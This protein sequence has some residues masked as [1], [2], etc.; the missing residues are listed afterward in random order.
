MSSLAEFAAKFRGIVNSGSRFLCLTHV[1]P[2]GDAYGCILAMAH[3]LRE[4]GK[5]VSL[6]SETRVAD[7]YKFLPG[8][9]W[10]TTGTPPAGPFNAR[11]IL[12]NAN[13]ERAGNIPL[14]KEI[15]SPI[16]NVDHH[17]SNI[18]YGDLAYI[19]PK[20]AS[21]GEIVFDL[22]KAAGM[23]IP[24][25]TAECLFVAISTDTGSFQYPSV[26]AST[27]HIAGELMEC[28][29]DLGQISRETYESNPPRRLL[30]MR[31]VLKSV[32]FDSQDRIGYFWIDSGSYERSGARPEDSEGMIDHIRSI[33]SVLVAV[34]FEEVADENL[35]RIS[36]R[37]KDKRIDVNKIAQLFGG[38]G[39]SAAAGAKTKG[40][41]ADI[42]EKVLAAIR[43][44]M[45]PL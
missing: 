6:W 23:P 25:T 39:H 37:S 3:S 31:E 13:L 40:A 1:R 11:I 9:E 36:L 17:A 15:S 22:L 30:L 16:I 2:D 33:H 10:I 7:R 5:E 12:D 43:A 18:G 19:E 41:K 28:G 32:S 34:L 24:K 8:S 14:P 35:I 42:E 20:R 44:A 21:C 45:P 4:M 29:L 38:G 26:T 27:F